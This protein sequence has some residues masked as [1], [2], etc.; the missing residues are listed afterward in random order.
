MNGDE[1]KNLDYETGTASVV[2]MHD[3]VR[4][5]KSL[6]PEGQ[7][8]AGLWVLVAGFLVVIFGGGQ[9]FTTI[10][11]FKDSIYS[12]ANYVPEPR[13]SLDGEDGEEEQ[14]A[15]IDDWMSDGKKVYN[16]CVA[17]HQPGG[18]GAPGQFPPLKGSEWVDGGT[19][20]LG[21]ILLNGIQGPFTVAGQTYN[22]PMPAWNALDD[23]KLA[24]VITYIRRE[25]GSLPEGE[26]GVV[27][28]EMMKAAREEFGGRSPWSEGE[29]KQIPAEEALP[30]GKVDLQTGEPL[31][32]GGG[33]E[34]GGEED[35]G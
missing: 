35:A 1:D 34:E 30:G 11:F 20:R 28:T 29:L 21:A 33:A 25:F 12:T 4:R 3:A 31:G 6:L 27:T 18:Q 14:V 23:E 8:V 19:K 26:D 22:Q 5:E 13:P 15:W 10:N 2:E 16:N 24:Q 7:A 17:C 9:L 32:A